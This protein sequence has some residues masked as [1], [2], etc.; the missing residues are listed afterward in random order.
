MGEW[1][2]GGQEGGR[3]GGRTSNVRAGRTAGGRSGDLADGGIFVSN[4]VRRLEAGGRMD[5]PVVHEQR[6][7]GGRAGERASGRADGRISTHTTRPTST[8]TSGRIEGRRDGLISTHTSRRTSIIKQTID[9][10][11]AHKHFIYFLTE[12][13]LARVYV[14]LEMIM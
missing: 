3:A 6:R 1:A 12:W 7:A 13:S 9:T 10:Q 14:D 5:Q 8:H 4:L 2:A 11:I